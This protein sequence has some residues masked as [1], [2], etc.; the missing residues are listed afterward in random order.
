MPDKSNITKAA[1]QELIAGLVPSLREVAENIRDLR[2]SQ[3][4]VAS[5]ISSVR[6]GC[7]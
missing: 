7:V 6:D 2:E 4:R 5:E 3:I 1:L